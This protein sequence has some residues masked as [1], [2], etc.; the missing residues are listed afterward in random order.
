M[1]PGSIMR[2]KGVPVDI[3]PGARSKAVELLRAYFGDFPMEIHS[4]DLEN[5]RR[6]ESAAS[7]YVSDEDNIWKKLADVI[8]EHS[9]VTVIAEY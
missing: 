2:S 3:T 6:M 5:L 7:I 8:K 1:R 9:I 4:D